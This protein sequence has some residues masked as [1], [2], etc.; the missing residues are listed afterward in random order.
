MRGF[1][2]LSVDFVRTREV[3]WGQTERAFSWFDW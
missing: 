2:E 3:S 1:I